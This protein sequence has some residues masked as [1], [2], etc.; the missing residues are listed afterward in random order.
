MLYSTTP[1]PSVFESLAETKYKNSK[2]EMKD[3]Y[4]K[5]I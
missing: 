5:T 3:S 1:S 4:G 2:L